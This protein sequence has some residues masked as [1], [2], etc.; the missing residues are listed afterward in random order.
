MSSQK[1]SHPLTEKMKPRDSQ[2]I[3]S[4]GV[5]PLGSRVLF[6]I[7]GKG[8]SKTTT[9]LNLLSLKESPYRKY[10][11]NIFL[12]SPSASAD[13]KLGDLYEE[14]ERDDKVYDTLN[15][16]VVNEITDR[17]KDLNEEHPKQQNLVIIDDCSH[18][19]PTGR[20]PS[21]ISGLFVN[22]RHLRSSVWLIA[23]KFTTI[24]PMIRNQ[25][26]GLFIF[27]TNS[28]SELKSFQTN[29][30][31]DEDVFAKN[32]K[33]ATSKPYGFLFLNLTGAKPKYYD[34]FDELLD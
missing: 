1:K 25:V 16:T 29:L 23:H 30:N 6:F 21:K 12:I 24:P 7:G 5:L 32:L 13:K 2:I 27:K 15:D 9:V 17:L 18:L 22:S 33:E 14:L 28:K 11:K 3:E 34:K 26:D 10:F 20:K 8:S 19:L 4:D 31:V